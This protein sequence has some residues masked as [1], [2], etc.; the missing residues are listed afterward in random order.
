MSMRISCARRAERFGILK[1]QQKPRT[2]GFRVPSGFTV[3]QTE[4]NMRGVCSACAE[5]EVAR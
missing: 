5:Q 1:V 2:S 3:T 4:V